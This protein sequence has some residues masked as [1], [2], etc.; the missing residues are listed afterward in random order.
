MTSYS[1]IRENAVK[2]LHPWHK[3]DESGQ[4]GKHAI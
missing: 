2:V 1:F 4:S 3:E